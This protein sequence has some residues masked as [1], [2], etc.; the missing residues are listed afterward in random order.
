MIFI[1]YFI[2]LFIEFLCTF[3]HLKYIMFIIIEFPFSGE[4]TYY[5]LGPLCNSST[6]SKAQRPRRTVGTEQLLQGHEKL[7]SFMPSLLLSIHLS[8]YLFLL[9]LS[10]ISTCCSHARVF[11]KT[12]VHEFYIFYSNTE[13]YFFFESATTSAHCV[14]RAKKLKYLNTSKPVPQN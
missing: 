14:F 6:V 7:F 2:F 4:W 5:R 12:L 9:F 3:F 8:S 10:L 1:L 13:W 11:G